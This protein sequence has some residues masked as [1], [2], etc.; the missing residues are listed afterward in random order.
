MAQELLWKNAVGAVVGGWSVSVSG[1]L[2]I[3]NLNFAMFHVEH[4][5]KKIAVD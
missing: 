1:I 3:E 4:S 5:G 2:G